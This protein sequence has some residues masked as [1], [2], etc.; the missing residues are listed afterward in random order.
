MVGAGAKRLNAFAE[1]RTSGQ[2][3]MRDWVLLSARK[4]F[5]T[6]W[7]CSTRIVS[8][9]LRIANRFNSTART[10]TMTRSRL[11]SIAGAKFLQVFPKTMTALETT[12]MQHAATTRSGQ[13]A[14]VAYFSRETARHNAERTSIGIHQALGNSHLQSRWVQQPIPILAWTVG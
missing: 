2:H 10:E 4:T 7:H 8:R 13:F 6:H 14:F 11:S 3:S 9:Q 1:S 5:I 12:S